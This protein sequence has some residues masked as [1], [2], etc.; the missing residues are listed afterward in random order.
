MPM[1]HIAAAPPVTA[2]A[3]ADC[4]SITAGILAALAAARQAEPPYR[5]WLLRDVLPAAVIADLQALPFIPVM[6]HG[7]SGRREVHNDQRT[8]ID[9]PSIAAHPVCAA[10]AG[11]LQSDTVVAALAAATGAPLD[12]TSLRIEYAQDTDGFFLEPHTDIGVKAFTMLIY[13]PESPDQADLGTDIYAGPDPASWVTR[14]PFE[15]GGGLIFVPASNTWH[16]FVRR[17]IRGV[18]RSLIINYVTPEWRAREQL[19]YPTQPVRC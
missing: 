10:L 18:R 15:P 4:A 13:M 2:T 19:S 5:H 17:P 7:E 11:A 14:T 8:Y 16:G 1:T 9:A 3:P 12:G 6:H